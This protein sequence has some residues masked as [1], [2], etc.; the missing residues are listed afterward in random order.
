MAFKVIHSAQSAG[1]LC[2]SARRNDLLHSVRRPT[3]GCITC[4]FPL[5]KSIKLSADRSATL[6]TFRSAFGVFFHSYLQEE[7][8][9][10]ILPLFTRMIF[11]LSIFK[12]IHLLTQLVRDFKYRISRY[13]EVVKL[14]MC[15]LVSSMVL[16][17][18]HLDVICL[19]QVSL[20]N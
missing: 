11:A 10:C 1:R 20:S 13:S 4:S 18:E 14:I 3:L 8:D 7:H 5:P 2:Q 17:R 6:Y 12:N 15:T 19:R 9:F 16:L